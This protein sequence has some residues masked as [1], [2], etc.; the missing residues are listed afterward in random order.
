MEDD[1][2]LIAKGEEEYFKLCTTCLNKID[3]LIDNLKSLRI[4]TEYTMCQICVGEVETTVT[5]LALPHPEWTRP[6]G[7]GIVLLDAVELGGMFGLNN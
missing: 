7:K 2:D 1:L 4:G 5:T 6:T 3:T